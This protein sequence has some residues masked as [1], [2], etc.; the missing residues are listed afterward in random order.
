MSSDPPVNILLVD[1]QPAKLMSYEVILRELGEN[2]ITAGSAAEALECLLKTDVA[3][4][5]MDV[6]MPEL[7]GFELVKMLREHP[8]FE[9]IAVIFVSAIQMSEMDRVRGYETGAVDYIP[10]P[11]VPQILRAKVKIFVELHRKTRQLEQ[12]NSELEERVADRTAELVKSLSRLG[13][14]EERMRLASEAAE[15]GTYDYDTPSD[16]FHYS[17]NLKRLLGVESDDPAQPRGLS[18][19]HPSRRPRGHAPLHVR[20]PGWQSRPAG[21]GVPHSSRGWVGALAAQSW[22]PVPF[23][24]A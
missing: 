5:L 16:V 24:R 8:R 4:I 9:K 14:S 10:V 17:A 19:L 18:R 22:A 11:V 7:D 13:E 15:F 23:E 6:C 3:L 1:D 2:L 21:T 12:L 20:P